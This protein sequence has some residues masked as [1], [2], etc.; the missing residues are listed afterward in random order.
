[1]LV[2]MLLAMRATAQ[3]PQPTVTVLHAFNIPDGSTPVA[4]LL[5]ASDGNF[6]G[7]TYYGGDDGAGCVQGCEGT[8]FKIT[9]QGQFTLLHTFVGGGTT[10]VYQQGRN[11]WGGL[12]E[13]P[14][15]YLYGTTFSG[16]FV[17]VA[18]QGIVYKISKTGQFQKIHDF[19]GFVGCQD[20]GNPQGS[21][22]LGHDG[23]FYGTTTSPP[24]FPI[25]FRINSTGDDYSVIAH[26][27]NTGLGTPQKGLVQASDGNLY[28]VATGGVY[29]IT[30]P[31]V[32]GPVY[33]FNTATDGSGT[34]ALIQAADGNLY[35]AN[36][37]GPGNTGTVF[38]I[39]LDGNF[40]KILNLTPSSTGTVPNALVESSDGT[41]WGTT[42]ASTVGGAGGKVYNIATD[43]TL[44]RSAFLSIS[45]TGIQP[46]APLI[47]GIDGK[48]Y[49]TASSYGSAPN[50]AGTVFVVDA[51]FGPRLTSIAITAPTSSIAVGTT[52]QFAAT[53]TYADAS[54]ADVTTQVT[55]N[56]SSTGVATIGASTG[57][58][59]GVAIGSSNITASLNG[60]T[61]NTLALSVTL[62]PLDHIVISPATATIASG[63]SQSYTAQG[64]DVSNNSLG[65][66]TSTT[67]FG[68]APD[69]SC[70]GATCTASAAGPHTVTGTNSGKTAQAT[71]TV[72]AATPTITFGPAPTPTYPSGF[73]VSATTTSDGALT[74]AAMSGPCAFVSA[75][76]NTGTFSSSAAGTCVLRASTAATTNFLAGATTQNVTISPATPTITFGPAPTPTY[77][78]GFTVSATTTSDGALTFAAM[79]GPCAFVSAI[80][81]TA[82]FSSSG[83]GT[84]VVRAS[85]AATTNFL[86]GATTQNVTI[87]PATGKT[88]PVIAWATPAPITYGTP[89][90]ATQL[91]ATTNVAG[92]F[93][94]SPR[95][96]TILSAGVQILTVT[97]A[98]SNTTLYNSATA[99]VTLQVNRATP[100]V[101]WLPVPIVYGTALGRLQLDAVTAVPGDFVYTPSAGTILSAGT[102]TLAATFVPRDTT[103][104][105][106]IAVQATLLVLKATPQITW[107]RPAAIA[108]GTPLGAAQLNA[109]SNVPGSFSYSPAAGTQLRQGTWTLTT[110]FT[111]SDG[112]NYQTTTVQVRIAV[113]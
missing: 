34:D 11:P 35:G 7:T 98:P 72:S 36:Y 14:D 108:V 101:L 46:G 44:L 28:G 113:R 26:F 53:G 68:I 96:G 75:T 70:V 33:F 82:T 91:N 48:L 112:D 84:C 86:A 83:A 63:G 2:A 18:A 71:L 54:T 97:F 21:L 31:G 12:I 30:P 74:F 87:S 89:L 8:V 76:A 57:L 17:S 73:T 88:T 19:C 64:F 43:G 95:R 109:T 94:Y 107:P 65:D 50:A 40:Q 51:G 81:S 32:F 9:P 55:W 58:A 52:Q 15:G 4:P 80:G 102:H 100:R 29:R 13:G 66:V 99:S 92:T 49:G 106:T 90:S 93:T 25:D 104:F 85:T 39:S 23:Y 77:P 10:P 1:M 78:S 20:G 79:S 5:Q 110:T 111:P 59:T 38:R 60:V 37:S 27:Y 67:T 69:G 62:G 3:P 47:Q 61:S 16:G 56:S 45:N 22:V 42:S 105:E 6:Y 24:A 103:N 41:L